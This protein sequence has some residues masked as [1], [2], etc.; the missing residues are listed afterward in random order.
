MLRQAAARLA[1]IVPLG[2]GWSVPGL[3]QSSESN[4]YMGVPTELAEAPNGAIGNKRIVDNAEKVA[5][6]E[7]TIENP[8]P[9]IYVFG[10]FGLAPT[11]VIEAEEGLIRA[12]PRAP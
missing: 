3:A 11:A 7:P 2:L 10:G 8:A 1:A 12:S 6:L 4:P 9:G 5:Y